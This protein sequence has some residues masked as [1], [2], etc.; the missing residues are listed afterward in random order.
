M[1]LRKITA[2]GRLLIP[3]LLIYSTADA[4]FGDLLKNLQKA[5]GIEGELSD[6]KIIEGLKEALS[7]G[8]ENAVKQVS[9]ADGYYRNPD[10]KIPLPQSVRKVEPALKM[11]GFGSQVEAFE[12][13]MNRAAEKAAP[14]AKEIFWEALKQ[15][16]F[17]DARKILNGSNDAATRYFEDKTGAKLETLFKPV[18]DSAMDQVAVT[19]NYQAL[20]SKVKSIPFATMPG[21]DL[22]QYVTDR[23]IS[24]LFQV[25]AEEERKIRTDPASRVTDLLKDVFGKQQ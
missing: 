25:L 15:L 11:I 6:G 13:S 3:L 7:V 14:Q 22:N 8:T 4:G 18:I 16:T 21:L 5:V 9:T 19:R 1:K 12:L 2:I 23:A 10:I 20:E 17:E 24:G